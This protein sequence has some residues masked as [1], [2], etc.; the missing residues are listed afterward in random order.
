MVLSWFLPL[1]NSISTFLR[2]YPGTP[3]RSYFIADILSV[4]KETSYLSVF[5]A[6][7]SGIKYLRLKRAVLMP[8]ITLAENVTVYIAD[9]S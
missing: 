2:M 7:G 8:L 6:K 4:L 5:Y 1:F 3:D 9:T